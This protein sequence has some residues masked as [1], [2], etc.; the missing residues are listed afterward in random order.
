MTVDKHTDE[1]K[2]HVT[3]LFTLRNLCFRFAVWAASQACLPA[4]DSSTFGAMISL[5]KT[6][7]SGLFLLIF[8]FIKSKQNGPPM[9]GLKPFPSCRKSQQSSCS[10]LP[11]FPGRAPCRC[12][13]RYHG[14]VAEQ[15]K[16]QAEQ[17][18]FLG[19]RLHNLFLWSYVFFFGRLLRFLCTDLL[20]EVTNFAS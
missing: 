1:S 7:H 6:A 20:Q 10:S 18:L 4:L 19:C 16:K 2:R 11:Q 17:F 13:V 5:L 9:A 3:F 14:L 8:C 12:C 15:L